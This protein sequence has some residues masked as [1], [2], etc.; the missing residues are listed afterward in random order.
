MAII[1]PFKAIRPV[2]DKAHL[3][4]SRSYDV[5]NSEEAGIEAQGNPYSFLPARICN[6]TKEYADFK[7]A[8]EMLWIANPNQRGLSVSWFIL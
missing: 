5:L 1:K 2:K 8:N 7:S 4:A 6:L 3:V